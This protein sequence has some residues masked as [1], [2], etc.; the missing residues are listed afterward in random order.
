MFIELDVGGVFIAPIFG[1]L[2]L[3]AAFFVPLS[4]LF[5]RFSIQKWVA[6]R[7]VFDVSVFVA[8]FGVVIAFFRFT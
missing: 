1:Y 3:S 8:L 5:D 7:P 6:N 2:V 4:L